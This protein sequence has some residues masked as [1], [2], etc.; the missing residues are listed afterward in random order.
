MEPAIL[1]LAGSPAR[2]G[3]AE[4]APRVRLGGVE[5]VYWYVRMWQFLPAGQAAP[6]WLADTLTVARLGLLVIMSVLIIRQAKG[7]DPDSVRQAHGGIDP[8]AGV[9]LAYPSQSWASR[10]AVAH[11]GV[12]KKRLNKQPQGTR[13]AGAQISMGRNYGGK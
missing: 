5:A 3:A 6:N 10:R 8:L 2:A 11:G 1:D 13:R 4:V 9:L 7:V 12:E